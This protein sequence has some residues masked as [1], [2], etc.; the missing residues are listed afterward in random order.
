MQVNGVAE[1]EITVTEANVCRPGSKY[2]SS[3][4][5]KKA[6]CKEFQTVPK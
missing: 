5:S 4:S 3:F 6:A 2:I 1:C